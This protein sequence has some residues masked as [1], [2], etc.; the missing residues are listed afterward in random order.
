MNIIVIGSQGFIG[1]H[2]SRFLQNMPNAE[3]DKADIL[4]LKAVDYTQ[5]SP[6]NLD[7]SAIFRPKSYDVCINCAGAAN[8]SLSFAQ[9]QTDFDLNVQYVAALLESIRIFN[10]NCKFINLSSAAVYGN[11][12]QIPVAETADIQPLSPYGFHKKMSELLCQ[13][14]AQ[15][16]GLRTVS[17]RIFSAFG[18]GLQKQ[19]FWDIYQKTK[20]NSQEILLFGTGAESRD[21]I[22]VQDLCRAIWLIINDLEFLGQALNVANGQEILIKDAVQTLLQLLNYRGDFYFNGQTRIG[23][24]LRWRADIERLKRLNYQPLFSLEAGLSNYAKWLQKLN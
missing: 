16:F 24:P 2:L 5:L 14:Y 18:E 7:F 12:A 21:F 20:N 15:C 19:L 8:V 3:V 23:D 10:P 1:Q 13:E 6:Q 11:P 22:Y 4:P 17:L 9:P